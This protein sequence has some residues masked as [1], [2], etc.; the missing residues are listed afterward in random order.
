M[1]LGSYECVRDQVVVVEGELEYTRQSAKQFREENK[2]LQLK[3]SLLSKLPDSVV[4]KILDLAE[5]E[6]P[7]EDLYWI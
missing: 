4:A 3:I 6:F 2:V 5:R 1:G 7:F